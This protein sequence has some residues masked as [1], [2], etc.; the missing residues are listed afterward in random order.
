MKYINLYKRYLFK[1]VFN[2]LE[3]GDAVIFHKDCIHKSNHNF[4]NLTISVVIHIIKLHLILNLK[5]KLLMN[6]K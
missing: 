4:S 5:N 2:Y 3:L 6:Y 1:E